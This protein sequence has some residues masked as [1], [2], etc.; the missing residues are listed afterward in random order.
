MIRLLTMLLLLSG[1]V[2]GQERDS[3]HVST[4]RTMNIF[5]K[6]ASDT[7]SQGHIAFHSSPKIDSLV[8]LYIRQSEKQY[9]FQGYRVQIYSVNSF[10]AD[11][12][13]LKKMRDDFEMTFPT[14][15]AYLKYIDPDFKIRVGNFTSRLEAV[16][17]LAKIKHLYPISYVVKTSI[18]LK[19]LS[20]VPMQDVVSDSIEM[21]QLQPEQVFRR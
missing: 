21:K 20:R 12:E 11:I 6:I 8:A 4:P 1:S 3:L 16:A 15:P 14:I 9:A 13:K 10:G 19:E 18:T 7:L 2:F 5:E 17:C